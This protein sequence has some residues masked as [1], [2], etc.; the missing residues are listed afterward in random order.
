MAESREPFSILL[1]GSD[2][3]SLPRIKDEFKK[4]SPLPTRL[5]I[6]KT[7]PDA[8]AKIR[9]DHYHLI[10]A[11]DGFENGEDVTEILKEINERK[12]AIPLIFLVR[13]GK[14]GKIRRALKAGA[15]DY[16]VKTE[17][18]F[19][20]LTRRLWNIYRTYELSP[21]QGGLGEQIAEES[22]KLTEINEKFRKLGIRDELTGLYN[23][24]YFQERLVEEFT[25]AIRY[26]HAI[27]CL[28]VDLDF[29]RRIN[30]D[31][32]HAVGDEVLKE[33]AGLLLESCRLSDL[34]SRFG[35]EEFAILLPHTD[36][37]GAVELAERLRT[38]FSEH[39]FLPDSHKISL[40]VSIGIS[41]F[42]EDAVQHRS[43]LL[44]F[45]DQALFRA[46]AAGR[47]RVSLYRDLVPTIGEA[48][49]QLKI[50]EDRILE[51]QKKLSEIADRAR[52]G[53]IESSKAMIKALESKDRLTA[54]HAGSVA[55]LSM[56]VAEAMGLPLDEVETVEHAGLLHDIGKICI[57]D[58]IL[59]KEG[60]Y[61]PAEYEAMKQHPC[62]G[63]RIVKPI[64]FLHEEA[65]L[66]LHH[67]EWFNGEGY[68]CRLAGNEIPLGSR[69]ISV[70]D[71]YDTMRLA[72]ERYKKTL[73][74]QEA[75]D[76]LIRCVGTQFDPEVV[77][78]FVQVLLMR[79]ELGADTYDKRH[80]QQA[81]GPQPP[82]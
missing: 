80:L 61:S 38:I 50:S 67:H 58:D 35:G 72:G 42:P 73:S 46:K 43:D 64:K 5:D 7:V 33:T 34:F 12:L 54:G 75:V 56:Q 9:K 51:F 24:R 81:L 29:F 77:Q 66:I 15:T 41:C 19:Q 49:P 65:T 11:D 55:R 63:Y 47:N 23:H 32:G 70:V 17:E 37:Q 30:E 40:T 78:A 18:G 28:L 48:L 10:L 22:Q 4:D 82:H 60:R 76:E 1:I 3:K 71:S 6:S 20:N 62:L 53:S 26:G 14:E 36:Y 16:L 52:R 8:L 21:H 45:S 27:S 13:P 25:R 31:L 68:P 79:K 74:V 39:T 69:I 2:E 44:N 59:L 57:S